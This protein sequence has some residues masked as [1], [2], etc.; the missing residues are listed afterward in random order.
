MK[1][2]AKGGKDELVD[3]LT[4][5]YP[6]ITKPPHYDV[7]KETTKV[8][9]VGIFESPFSSSND[10]SVAPQSGENFFILNL[11]IL[12]ILFLYILLFFFIQ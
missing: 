1:D 5:I 9:D 2:H 3:D 10:D 11:K 8:D 6:E 12:I 4:A 7:T